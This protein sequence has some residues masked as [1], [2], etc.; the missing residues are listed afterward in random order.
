MTSL[1]LAGSGTSAKKTIFVNCENTFGGFLFDRPATEVAMEPMARV[2]RLQ[3]PTSQQEA[4]YMRLD[5]PSKFD[6]C[7]TSRTR[8]LVD[9]VFVVDVRYDIRWNLVPKNDF[10][11]E[12]AGRWAVPSETMLTGAASCRWLSSASS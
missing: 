7:L 6:G 11:C 4:L 8:D 10:F 12:T 3:D 5:F 2:C 1:F 9:I